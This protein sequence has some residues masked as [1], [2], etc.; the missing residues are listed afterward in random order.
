MPCPVCTHAHVAEINANV[1]HLSLRQLERTYSVSRSSL[2]RHQQRCV[3]SAR[4]AG[5]TRERLRAS[6]PP[7]NPLAA[8]HREAQRLYDYLTT[9][10]QPLDARQLGIALARVLVQL[11]AAPDNDTVR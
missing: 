7:R 5:D 3:P 1:A 8:Y 9:T 10:T 2:G 6:V 4:T 11:T